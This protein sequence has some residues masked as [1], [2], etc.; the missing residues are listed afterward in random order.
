MGITI[1]QKS[2][3]SVKKKNPKIAL[4]LSGGAV[5]GGAYKLG[6]LKAMNDLMVNHDIGDFDIFIGLSAGALIAA[7]VAAGV[8]PEEMIKSFDGKSQMFTQ[9]RWLD[10][11]NPNLGEIITK[12]LDFVFKL[13][14]AAPRFSINF[15]SM[16]FSSDKKFFRSLMEL[17]RKPNYRNADQVVKDLI[18]IAQAS[19][20]L[21]SLLE[22]LPSGIFDNSRLETYI[23][24]NIRRNNLKNSF[25]DLYE[26]LGKELYIT[27][28][29]LDAGEPVVFGHDENDSLSISEAIQASTALPGFYKPARIRG[30]DYC[31]GGVTT[32]A[33]ID[34]AASHGADLIICY[35]PFRPFHNKLLIRFYKDLSTYVADKPHIADG[36]VS[37][38]LNQAF[39]TLLHY[40]LQMALRR[41]EHDPTFRGDIVLIEP[42]VHD[43]NFFEINPVAFWERAKAAELGYLS[44]RHSLEKTYP[45]IKKILG[46]YGVDTT[47][48]YIDEDAKKIQSTPHDETVI[49]ILGKARLKRDIRLV[50]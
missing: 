25:A 20:D 46:A 4:V 26:K 30:V 39:R 34:V 19:K 5:A 47:M 42:D 18:K 22:V 37:A 36:G 31:D 40:R 49:N 6:G 21:P 41:F 50:M 29:N 45:L 15:L 33:N 28:L 32:T 14:T 10:F 8:S 38:V 3:L 27:A 1:V 7:P 17:V 24:Q 23:R 48:M 2:D 16:V 13:A 35:N 12:P 11:Y 43:I 44:V 9:L